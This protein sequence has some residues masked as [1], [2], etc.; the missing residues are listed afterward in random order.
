MNSP[1]RRCFRAWPGWPHL[2]FSFG[3][4][5]LVTVWFGF[6]FAGADWYT[7]HR[8]TRVRIHFNAELGLPL[9][10]AFS[11]IY[12]SIYLLFFAAPLVLRTRREI[13]QLATTQ[14]LTISI[15]GVCFLLLP[16]QLAFAPVTDAELGIWKPLF[17]FADRLNL[18]HNLVPSLH[19]ALSVVCIETFATHSSVMGRVTLRLWGL[20]ISAATV[21]TH[22]HHLLDAVTGY[23]LAFA[24]VA[25]VRSRHK[26]F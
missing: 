22:Q 16:A 14:F 12:M 1:E 8:T 24:M 15:A 9:I 19:V 17:R 11:L 6:V 3:I 2:R 13:L 23:V 21:F 5:L 20:L 7:A 26:F 10:P 25:T 18:D 4:I